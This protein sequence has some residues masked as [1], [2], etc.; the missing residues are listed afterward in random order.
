[1]SLADQD[2]RPAPRGEFDDAIVEGE[3]DSK[4][5]QTHTHT[6]THTPFTYVC[7]LGEGDSKLIYTHTIHLLLLLA[8]F[9]HLQTTQ[10]YPQWWPPP[11]ASAASSSAAGA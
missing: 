7:H 1:M 4:L 10:L 3:G 6:H 8:L 11:T 9:S 5:V 2:A